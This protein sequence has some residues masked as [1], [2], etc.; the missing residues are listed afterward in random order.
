MNTR[1]LWRALCATLLCVA[2]LCGMAVAEDDIALEIDTANF[3]EEDVTLEMDENLDVAV[4][5]AED[6]NLGLDLSLDDGLALIEIAPEAID[7]E[8][9][10]L[11]N[12]GEGEGEET[13]TNVPLKVTYNGPVLTKTYD[14]TRNAFART[15]SGSY[16]YLITPPKAADFSVEPANDA[17]RTF[18]DAHRDVMVR[19]TRIKSVEQFSDSNVGDYTL[20]FTFGLEGNDAQY[21]NAQSVSVP[22]KIE[23]RE[24]KI[25]PRAGLSKV[26]GTKDPAYPDNSW[27]SN[28]ESS[29]LHQD[30][31]GQPGYAVPVN[32]QGNTLVL[33]LDDGS[34]TTPPV[35]YLLEEAKKNGTKFFPNDGFLSRESGEDVGTYRIT[36]G[37][38]DFGS[39]FRI[40]L[41]SEVFTITPKNLADDNINV[42]AIG[43]QTYTGKAI[44][45]DEK[46]LVVRY[47][48]MTLKKDTDFTVKYENNIEV[49]TAKVTLTGKGNYTGT[50]EVTFTIIKTSDGGS[51][52]GGSSGGGSSGGGGSG[53]SGCGVD[54]LSPK[55][56]RLTKVKGG[57]KQIQVKWKKGKKV[58]GYQIAYSLTK[59]FAIWEDKIVR[60]PKKTSVTI[61]GLKSKKT[62][63][64]RIRTYKRLNG[65]R[66]WSP[67]SDYKKVK[68]R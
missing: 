65:K 55:G 21:Y 47:G 32:M 8:P 37:K 60:D 33:T 14:L 11:T 41:N 16:T 48:T 67:W 9:V 24:V 20:K 25:T 29:P 26:Y 46:T 40:T 28:D 52:G 27:L 43:N 66:H 54:E 34:K 6:L 13:R 4:E 7:G 56:T 50:R 63:Y 64:V 3:A 49:G 36:I 35:K 17:D 53:S 44:E 38:M 59:D 2:L 18:F 23:R 57:R 31:S 61:K 39:N 12:E 5:D 10:V 62:Y 68:T 51:S 22:A 45:L 58:T 19:V 1:R 30:I 42:D 15:S